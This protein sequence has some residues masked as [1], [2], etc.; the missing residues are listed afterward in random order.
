MD[1]TG[2][3]AIALAV[4]TAAEEVAETVVSQQSAFICPDGHLICTQHSIVC[5]CGK[6]DAMQS[7]NCK[8]STAIAASPMNMRFRRIVMR[9]RPF[10]SASQA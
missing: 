4:R 1:S 5:G 3:G 2:A 6:A 7:L 10:A 8:N 9:L